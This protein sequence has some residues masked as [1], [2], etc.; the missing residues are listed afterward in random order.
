MV[1]GPVRT[2]AEASV[3][4]GAFDE[5]FARATRIFF[6]EVRSGRHI[7]VASL[8]VVEELE[9]A[10]EDV[11]R[12]FGEMLPLME[13]VEVSAEARRLQQAYLKARIVGPACTTDALHV[14]LATVSGCRVIVS[15]NC[16]HIVLTS[17]RS[18][19]TTP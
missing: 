11:R 3:F 17:R 19:S 1:A 12:L 2:S 13:L 7:L 14:A 9:P 18:R 15:W 16:G 4:G 6:D 5:E 8:A 10:P